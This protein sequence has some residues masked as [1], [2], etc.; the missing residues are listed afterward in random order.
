[1]A[2]AK[3]PTWK[4]AILDTRGPATWREGLSLFLKG[5]FMG[6]ANIIP[7]VSGGTIALI[8]GIYTEL[9]LAI[10][11]F[12]LETV[13]YLGR[14]RIKEALHTLH[15]RFLVVLCVGVALSILSLAHVVLYVFARFPIQIWSLFFGLILSSILVMGLKTKGW[16]GFGGLAFVLGTV[17]SYL[18]VG[19]IPVTTPDSAWL[20]FLAGVVAICTMI[21]P[22]LS[23]SFLLLILGKYEYI[24]GALK[25][26]FASENLVILSV[27]GLGCLVGIIAFSRVLSALLA[28]YENTTMAVLTG[29]M[30]GSLRKIWPWKEVLQTQV[31]AGKVR[32]I[33]EANML[34]DRFDVGFLVAIV[35]MIA[36]FLAVLILERSAARR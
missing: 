27:F 28:R 30:C 35:L 19:L 24:I 1:M 12:N 22:G 26:P 9:L 13:R 21:L 34:P 5:V 3:V 18:L 15:L 2:Q 14:F 31:V 29:I 7:G 36:G 20:I 33:E 25:N 10:R 23:G 32:I 17:A 11:S 4:A 8:T 6:A 16:L